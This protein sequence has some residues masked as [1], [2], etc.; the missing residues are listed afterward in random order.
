MRKLKT[1]MK[2]AIDATRKA[3]KQMKDKAVSPDAFN[4][5][6]DQLS[7]I[8]KNLAEKDETLLDQEK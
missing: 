8:Q 6:K 3:I 4:A 1:R 7:L 5:L 2:T